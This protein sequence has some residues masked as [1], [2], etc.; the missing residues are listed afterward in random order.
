MHLARLASGVSPPLLLQQRRISSIISIEN[1]IYMQDLALSPDLS[2]LLFSI[3]IIEHIDKLV[4]FKF[5]KYFH[6]RTVVLKW[7]AL[8]LISDKLSN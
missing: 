5:I 2:M 3:P 7:F 6:S 4:F 8:L 1:T